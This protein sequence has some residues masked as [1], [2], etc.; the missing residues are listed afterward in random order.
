MWMLGERSRDHDVVEDGGGGGIGRDRESNHECRCGF[1]G[2]MVATMKPSSSCDSMALH[3]QQQI[4]L[5]V[6]STCRYQ[7]PPGGF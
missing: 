2:D 7:M 4:A 3:L 6:L 5:G 1:G